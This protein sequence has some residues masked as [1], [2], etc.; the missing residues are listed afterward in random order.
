LD[1]LKYSDLS[2]KYAKGGKKTPT[3]KTPNKT[4]CSSHVEPCSTQIH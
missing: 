1:T 2:Y 3:T 4:L